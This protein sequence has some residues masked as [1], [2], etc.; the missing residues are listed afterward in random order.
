MTNILRPDILQ[1]IETRAESVFRKCA[2]SVGGY[3][4]V[5]VRRFSTYF[6][7]LTDANEGDTTLLCTGLC[8]PLSVQSYGDRYSE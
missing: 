1:G 5:Y 3:L 8:I 4:D 2:E 7:I 6:G